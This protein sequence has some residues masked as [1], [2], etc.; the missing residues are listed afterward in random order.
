MQLALNYSPQ[1]ADLLS[2]A[3]INFDLYKC[4]PWDDM[5]A[6]AYKQRPAYVHFSLHT[7][8]PDVFATLSAQ[9]IE[10]YLTTTQTFYV[11]L[12]LA[13]KD[14]VFDPHDS[15]LRERV[16]EN[17]LQNVR[18]VIDVFGKERVI[19][20]NLFWDRRYHLL[21]IVR[22]ARLINQIIAETGC[23]LLLDLAH[24][25]IAAQQMNQD[26]RVYI[27]SL[28]VNHVR[29][30]HVTGLLFDAEEGHNTDH[31]PMTPDDWTIV[32]WA[33]EQIRAGAWSRPW[34]V[35]L[36]YGGTG[37]M[38]AWRS[39]SEALAQDVPRLYQLCADF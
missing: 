35:S 38:F 16:L 10:H 36:E 23:G 25:T 31:F 11:N 19:V 15:C 13:A 37:A 32:E 39:N 26:P 18:Q 22:E 20:E 6:E 21:P 33:L 12:H 9:S 14:T 8:V 3:Q 17:M 5:L 2:R 34:G 4:P 29:E 7:G 28:P 30:V 27:A 24:A 1:A